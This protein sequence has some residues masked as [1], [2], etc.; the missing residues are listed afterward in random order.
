L[1]LAGISLYQM[2]I[3]VR[4][5]VKTSIIVFGGAFLGA[6]V[7]WLSTKYIPNKQQFGFTRTLTNQAVTLSQILLLGLSSTLFVFT[8]RFAN[9]PGKKKTLISLCFLIPFLAT[10]ATAVIYFVIKEWLLRHF[11]PADEPLMRQYFGWLPI[12]ILLLLYLV[13]LEQYLSVHMKVAISSFMREILLRILNIML[14]LL[15]ALDYVSFNTLVIGTVLL[16]FVPVL[17]LLAIASRSKDFG[18]SFN[19]RIFSKQEYIE[20]L[21][22]AWYHFLL[23]ISVLLMGSLDVLLIPFYD[24]N[25]FAS[26]AVYTVA[27]YIISF[28]QIPSKAFLA[29]SFSVLTK[30]FTDSDIPKAKDIFTRSSLNLLIPSVGI[31]VILI[32]NLQNIV[33]II[34]SGKNYSGLVPVFLILFA[35]R[36]IDIATGMNDQ[37]LSITN[38]YKFNFYV[39]IFVTVILFVMLRLLIPRLGVNGAAISTSVTL[40]IFNVVKYLFIWKKLDMQPFSRNTVLVFLAAIPALAAG[41]FFPYFFNA[42]RHVYVHSFIDAAMRSSVIVVIYL[43]MLLWLKP[44]KDLEEYIIAIR[45]NKRLY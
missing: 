45:K 32:C 29:A 9:D 20:M 16:Y 37:V 19:F 23:S 22:F 12:Y 34:G 2:G 13:I 40:I 15:Y 38:Y 42:E 33:A 6:V 21:H 26:V 27:M 24:H 35:G 30:A 43:M 11:Q 18:F 10:A 7:I 14:I 36:F 8:H 25:G 1:F 4:Q 3:V 41:Y 17:I 39:S 44:S 28:L 31:A 5:S